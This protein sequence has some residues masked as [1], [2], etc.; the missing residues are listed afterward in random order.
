VTDQSNGALRNISEDCLDFKAFCDYLQKAS[1]ITLSPGKSYLV[2]ARIRHIMA[3]HEL[4]SLSELISALERKSRG[5]HQEIIDAMTTNETFW[6]RDDYPFIYFSQHLLPLWSSGVHKDPVIKIW[7]AACSSGQEPY[8]LAMLCEEYKTS[9][10]LTKR[11]E[12]LATDLS[13]NILQKAKEGM[14][15]RLSIARGLSDKRLNRFFSKDTE[16]QWKANNDLKRYIQFRAL[17][18]LES[19]QSLGTFDIIFCRNV[20]IYFTRETKTDILERMHKCLKPGGLLCL[21]SSESLAGAKDL[22]TMVHCKPGII[23]QAK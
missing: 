3:V 17:N 18:L 19:Y 6:F 16:S 9:N 13:S 20:L 1:G 8:S 22:F 4:S 15:D 7:S 23:Y 14:F 12:I 10:N 2:S 21:G 5:L 11:V